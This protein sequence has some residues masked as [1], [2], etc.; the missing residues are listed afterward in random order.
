MVSNAS[1]G[2]PGPSSCTTSSAA[3][4]S[5]RSRIV[6]ALGPRGMGDGIG[7][8]VEQH[9]LQPPGVARDHDR[10][11]RGVDDAMVWP[12]SQRPGPDSTVCATSGTRS[13]GASVELELA[14]LQPG[15]IDELRDQGPHTAAPRVGAGS[16]SGA[17]ARRRRR[18]AGVRPAADSR[19][20]RSAGC[21]ARAPAQARNSSCRRRRVRSVM[22]RMTSTPA[23]VAPASGWPVASNQCRVP[24]AAPTVNS[25]RNASPRATRCCGVSAAGNGMPCVIVRGR[26]ARRSPR[27]EPS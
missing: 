13:S 23:A 25:S 19:A 7:E 1:T 15:G 27:P 5:R 16:G 9:L 14:A 6:D 8:Q 10:I 24:S 26:R 11:V 12:V 17:A 3:P 22:S 18:P 2:I 20:G 4:P 21:A